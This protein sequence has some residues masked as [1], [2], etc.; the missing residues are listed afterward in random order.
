LT[1]R[2]STLP[3]AQA[4]LDESAYQLASRFSNAGVTLFTDSAGTVPADNPSLGPTASPTTGYLGLSGQ[5][6]V[7][8][9]V[10]GNPA[11]IQQGTGGGPALDSGDNTYVMNV[12]NN[13]FGADNAS[14]TAQ[15]FNTTGLGAS[16]TLSVTLPSTGNIINY[17][18]NLISSMAQQYSQASSNKT[19]QENYNQ[20]LVQ[21]FDDVTGVSIDSEMTNMI[22]VQQAYQANARMITA[23]SDLFTELLGALPTS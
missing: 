5:L 12:L 13:A 22:S 15:T 8:S 4:M 18:Q 17:T 2:D 21:N 20:T 6:Q 1:L 14:G 11:L 16:G 7:N 9:A 23:V 19:Y 3:Q 10:V